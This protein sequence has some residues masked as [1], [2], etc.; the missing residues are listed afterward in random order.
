MSS[1][2]LHFWQR[3]NYHQKCVLYRL[4]NNQIIHPKERYLNLWWYS[5]DMSRR[6]EILSDLLEFMKHD[7]A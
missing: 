3:L 2:S 4:V 7:K 6:E 1:F 5:L